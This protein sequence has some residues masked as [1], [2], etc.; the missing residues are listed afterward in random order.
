MKGNIL[1]IETD[2]EFTDRGVNL[3]TEAFSQKEFHIFAGCVDAKN[4]IFNTFLT[5]SWQNM[6][7]FADEII[8]SWGAVTLPT[9]PASYAPAF[10]THLKSFAIFSHRI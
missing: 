10:F 3:P 2:D 5:I 8:E 7:S 1:P 9:P 6:Q 4:G